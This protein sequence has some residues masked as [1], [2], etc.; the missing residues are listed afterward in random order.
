M[1]NPVELPVG[2]SIYSSRPTFTGTLSGAGQLSITGT[3]AAVTLA[4]PNSY[5]GGTS[6]LAGS[7]TVTPTGTLGPGPVTVSGPIDN[8]VGGGPSIGQGTLFLDS[9]ASLTSGNASVLVRTGGYV[10]FTAPSQAALNRLDPASVG[11]LGI[12]ADSAAP[13][14]FSSH[15]NLRLGA[16]SLGK[17][18]SNAVTYSG[19]LTPAGS[20]YL[21]G[22]QAD[23]TYLNTYDQGTFAVASLL[24]DSPSSARSVNLGNNG[25]TLTGRVKL[26]NPANS[27]TGGTVVE[28]T[29]TIPSILYFDTT[30]THG[31]TPLGTGPLTVHG[32]LSFG[33]A[34]GLG[35][36]PNQVL[37]KPG[38]SLW[39]DNSFGGSGP[40]DR[41]G[42]AAPLSLDS[43][44]TVLYLGAEKTGTVHYA[45]RSRLVLQA[46]SGTLTAAS[47]ARAARGTLE[48]QASASSFGSAAQFK[49]DTTAGLVDPVTSMVA[50][51]VVGLKGL[52]VSS[53]A[54]F[55]TIDPA[56][57]FQTY[58]YVFSFAPVSSTEVVNLAASTSL[59]GDETVHAL[60]FSANWTLTVPDANTLS[61]ASGG[62]ILNGSLV[63]GGTLAF[64]AAEAVVHTAGAIASPN[65]RIASAI[66]GSAGLTKSG[67]RTLSLTANN[68]FTGG[69][70]VNDGTLLI[71]HPGALNEQQ[72][73]PITVH[74]FGTLDTGGYDLIT[75][76]LTGAGT[77]NNSAPD[78]RTLTVDTLPAADTTFAG[79]I[80]TTEPGRPSNLA[81][82]KSGPGTLTLTGTNRSAAPITVT[83]GTLRLAGTRARSGPYASSPGATLEFL[84][85][86]TATTL[87]LLGPLTLAAR[88]TLTPN[89]GPSALSSLNLTPTGSL[90]LTN[91]T[92][93]LQNPSAPDAHPG[94]PSIRQYLRDN[95][96]TSSTPDPTNT[97]SLAYLDTGTHILVQLTLTG[98]ANLDGILNADDYALLDRGFATNGQFWS[99]GDLNYDGQVTSADYLLIDRTYL[100]T[101]SP[102]PSTAFL[103]ARESQFGAA[104]VHQLLIAIPEPAGLACLFAAFPLFPRRRR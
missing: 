75:P 19:T 37:L 89:A 104:Y 45:G 77:V 2:L 21:L 85:P 43:A 71:S 97:H 51:H 4:A 68:S 26:T 95:Q 10:Q 99:Q 79:S 34:G 5:A 3:N 57:T 12:G 33:L 28:S 63:T 29:S 88:L 25:M 44:R 53:N 27:Y 20:T 78:I 91:N 11:A 41:W 59:A 38:S 13:L 22:G 58:P 72:P 14:D 70:V 40:V 73:N 101:H 18:P 30:P 39:F 92:L 23:R 102:A 100:L 93:T 90:D 24:T 52:D 76:S 62:L 74:R 56:G 15:P 16:R 83:A 49:T 69:V 96:L 50:P 7:L 80:G 48:L 94:L 47:L 66:T 60:R 86:H 84:S 36:L 64:G 17:T 54:D 61:V 31:Q 103:A 65:S 8:F 32:T 67:V 82:T 35:A 98:D 1:A 55:L 9:A 6:A 42:D 87:T 81:L 46:G